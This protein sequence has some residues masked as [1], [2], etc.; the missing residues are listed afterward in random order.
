MNL[1]KR[2]E[3]RAERQDFPIAYIPVIDLYMD[4]VLC[5]FDDAFPYNENEARLTKAMINNYVKQKIIPAPLKK[6][7]T[8]THIYSLIIICL[9][10]RI[11]SMYEIKVLLD[12]YFGKKDE[13]KKTYC[14]YLEKKQSLNEMLENKNLND[15]KEELTNSNNPL[16][17]SLL[18]SYYANILSE[19]ARSLISN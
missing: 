9:L 17:E 6:K 14:L 2:F 5:L 11:L 13:L 8:A 15:I 3:H 16:L 18:L 4:Q 12:P 7:Y 1:F 10:K 19:L